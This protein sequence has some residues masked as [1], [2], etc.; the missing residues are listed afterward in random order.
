VE[1]ADAHTLGGLRRERL[2]E[3]LP[4]GVVLQDVVVQVEPALGPG[5]PP[6]PVVVGVGTV[7][8]EFEAVPLPKGRVTG[9]GQHPLQSCAAR[10]SVFR[11]RG[12]LVYDPLIF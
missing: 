10:R 6:Q 11:E 8:E 4:R 5:D 1:E 7:L 9:S 2:G 12:V 3:P